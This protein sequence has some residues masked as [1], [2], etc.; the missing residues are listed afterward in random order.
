MT[1]I[2]RGKPLTDEHVAE[3]AATGIALDL[4]ADSVR[5]GQAADG[6]GNF[7]VEGGP[8][9]TGVEFRAR[10]VKRGIAPAA[11]VR[12]LFEELVVLTAEGAFRA[13]VHDYV[14]FLAVE[15]VQAQQQDPR[16]LGEVPASL[17]EFHVHCLSLEVLFEA[18]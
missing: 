13:L 14:L 8:A 7:L 18:G 11:Q 16:R 17:A 1:R 10:N 15:V 3:V 5:V 4:D 6:A 2:C 9:A 12:P